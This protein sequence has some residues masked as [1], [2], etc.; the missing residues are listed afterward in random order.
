MN[1]VW[2]MYVRVLHR[3]EKETE[4]HVSI[5]IDPEIQC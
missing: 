1:N 4:L 5:W 2:P 3:T